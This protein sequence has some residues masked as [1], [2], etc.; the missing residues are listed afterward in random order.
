MIE[1]HFFLKNNVVDVD[2]AVVGVSKTRWVT[3][4]KQE[5]SS[6]RAQAIM[7]QHRFDVLPITESNG[8]VR[9][10]FHTKNWSDYNSIEQKEIDYSDVMS[11]RT[12]L[13]SLIKS[14]AKEKRL[15]YFLE[16]EGKIVGL[17]S[18]ANLNCRQ[19]RI[20]IFSLVSELEIRLSQFIDS[21]M[22]E[23]DILDS[24]VKKD[25]KE[26]YASDQ[27]KGLE[28]NLMEYLYLS[29]L[30]NLVAKKHLYKELAYESRTKFEDSLGSISDLRNQAAHPTRTLIASAESVSKLWDNIETVERCLFR[31]RQPKG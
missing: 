27:E 13:H 6:E 5:A 25:I 10:Y 8:I 2:A 26:R 21:A 15:F 29:D 28:P 3:V 12:P 17:I 22:K 7:V 11:F 16:N 30:I 20:F 1:D 4:S 23:A 18:V 14:F 31:L 24:G 19:V 9:E